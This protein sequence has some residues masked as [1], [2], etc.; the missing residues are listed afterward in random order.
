MCKCIA[1]VNNPIVE[2]FFVKSDRL[3][4]HTKR[5]G[6]ARLQAQKSQPA[7][8]FKMQAARTLASRK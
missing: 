6:K 1:R 3:L 5:I 4:G 7:S 8:R 2:A